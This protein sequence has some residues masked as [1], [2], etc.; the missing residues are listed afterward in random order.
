MS[1]KTS[2]RY[3]ARNNRSERAR[4]SNS[5]RVRPIRNVVDDISTYRGTGLSSRTSHS[6]LGMNVNRG[7]TRC[8]GRTGSKRSINESF[9]LYS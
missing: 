5:K 7:T 1:L 2:R 8:N 9:R 4:R 3:L 6:S